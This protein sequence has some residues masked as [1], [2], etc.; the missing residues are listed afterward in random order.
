MSVLIVVGNPAILAIDPHWAA[1]LRHAVAVGAYVGVPPPDLPTVPFLPPPPVLMGSPSLL[2]ASL[3]H[4][5]P[6]P[7]VPAGGAAV[8]GLRMVDVDDDGRPMA[9]ERLQQEGMEVRGPSVACRHPPLPSERLQQE[10]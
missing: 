8:G 7:P 10:V 1:L 6:P 4:P 2:G 3:A 5:L 9:S